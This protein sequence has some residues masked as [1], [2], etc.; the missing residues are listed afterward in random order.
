[1]LESFSNYKVFRTEFGG[2]IVLKG[3]PVDYGSGNRLKIDGGVAVTVRCDDKQGAWDFVR[4]LLTESYQREFVWDWDGLFAMNKI[5]LEE[6]IAWNM[7]PENTQKLLLTNLENPVWLEYEELSQDEVDKVMALIDS[8]SDIL[9]HD[10][11][12]WS[13]IS[14]SASEFFSGQ[15]TA[16]DTARIIQSRASRYMAET[17]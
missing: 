17:G 13:I 4:I 12:L 1:V 9:V 2:E 6:G 7:N 10:E 5:I 11:I 15:R 14:E 3:F 16:Q 8:I